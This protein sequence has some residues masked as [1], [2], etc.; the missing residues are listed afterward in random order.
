MSFL[1][2][3]DPAWVD[4]S[5]DHDNSCQTPHEMGAA[6]WHHRQ[7]NSLA[8]AHTRTRFAGEDSRLHHPRPGCQGLRC[9]ASLFPCWRITLF[10]CHGQNGSI[11]TLPLIIGPSANITG[12]FTAKFEHKWTYFSSFDISNGR[13]KSTFMVYSNWTGDLILGSR[14]SLELLPTRK[15]SV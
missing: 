15:E 10:L 2:A 12:Q 14:V 3:G 8:W 9:G 4:Q 6:D 1:L 5:A 11:C 7:A 13:D